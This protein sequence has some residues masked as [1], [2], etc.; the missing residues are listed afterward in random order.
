M[1]WT[2]YRYIL[3]DLL[4]LLVLVAVV[5]VGLISFVAAIK[6]MSEGLL[7]AASLLKFIGFTS[8]T[9]L[10]FA[11]PFAGAFASTLVFLRMASDNEI[12]ACMASGMSYLSV[13]LPVAV[14]GLAMTMGMFLLSN[15]VL[16]SFYRAAEE[17]VE[18]DLMTM[19]VAQLNSNQP[20]TRFPGAVL[21]ADSA[22]RRPV[23]SVE[24]A[25]DTGG[26]RERPHLIDVIQLRGVV[27]AQ[28]NEQGRMRSD[29]TAPTAQVRVFRDQTNRSW[30]MITLPEVLY[31]NPVR[32]ELGYARRP[33]TWPLELPSPFQDRPKFF[34]WPELR[35]VDRDPER[36]RPVRRLKREL[37]EAIATQ[38]LHHRLQGALGPGHDRA[39]H[40]LTLL[41]PREG[42]R[43]TFTAPSMR[44][45]REATVL[46]SASGEPAT[47]VYRAP[48]RPDRRMEAARLVMRVE[49]PRAGH[50]PTVQT[51]LEDVRIY[52]PR[53]PVSPVERSALTLPRMR[54]SEPL[55][56]SE[57]L[58]M[59][60]SAM[61]E[62]AQEAHY[63]GAASVQRALRQLEEELLEL[64][65]AIVARLHFRAAVATACL[66]ALLLGAVL[67][68]H[69][70]GKLP[71]VVCFWSFLSAIMTLIL[72]SVG[73]N[74]VS[75][76]D[77]T[78]Y[79][80]LGVLWSGNVAMAVGAA[81]VYCLLAR[82]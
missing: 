11:L 31:Y 51:E 40:H 15:F 13:L 74:M 42:E 9:M 7:S 8:P 14:L 63:D 36:F 41:G 21:Y 56:T 50:E 69:L 76:E 3:A 12:V 25:D 35:R 33:D 43:F 53:L 37:A 68:M 4:K 55:L 72:I 19:L 27:L 34:S 26:E 54:W 67:S 30:A 64:G 6:P 82:N 39:D 18:A 32:G 57:L 52:D 38:Q 80:G 61:R 75:D 66:M 71:L 79:V 22:E 1:P 17:T 47:V 16:P 45:E 23:S 20:F 62:L 46:A 2:L 60:L 44:R 59:E 73:E 78:P 77:F 70:R 65:R 10:G 48:G 24:V 49:P 29:V 28:M 81:W 5:M 58:G